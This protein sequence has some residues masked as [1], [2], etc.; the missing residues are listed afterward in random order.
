MK[1]FLPGIDNLELAKKVHGALARLCAEDIGQPVTPALL[2]ALRYR[3]DGREF[4]AQVGIPHPPG[5]GAETVVAIFPTT[6]HYVV[7]TR[8]AGGYHRSALTLPRSSVSDTEYF[9]DVDDAVMEAKPD[10]A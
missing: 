7:W 4:L 3:K 6:S 10:R 2:F 8:G 9:N 5:E 1:F